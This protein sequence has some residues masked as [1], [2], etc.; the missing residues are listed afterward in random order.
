M[1]HDPWS[2]HLYSYTTNNP[3][4][5]IDPTGHAPAYIGQDG[6]AHVAIPVHQ[7]DGTFT[8]RAPYAEKSKSAGDRI[9]KGLD[10]LGMAGSTPMGASPIVQ[11]IALGADLLNAGIFLA[12]G[13][14]KNAGISLVSILPFGDSLKETKYGVGFA[15]S[16]A[17]NKTVWNKIKAT[18]PVNPGTN[19]P[20]SFEMSTDNGK[21]WVHANATKHMV[22]YSETRYYSHGRGMTEQGML[23]SFNSAVEHAPVQGIKFE[24]IMNIDQWELIF[25]KPRGPGQ[26]P[27]VK[28]AVFR[29]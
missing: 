13:E 27:V 12:K 24:E 7:G 28:H 17:K 23:K 26:F 21:F 4:N 14:F 1:A 16:T 18:Q 29:P 5:Y 25:S 15:K 6:K 19:I 10:V 20:K 11:G 9:Q 3:V 2:Q 22:E 8:W